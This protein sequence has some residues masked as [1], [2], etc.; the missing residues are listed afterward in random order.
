MRHMFSH[1]VL[2]PQR[3][4]IEA[5]PW[6]TPA[7]SGSFSTLFGSRILR[8]LDYKADPHDLVLDQQGL[9]RRRSGLSRPLAGD[10]LDDNEARIIDGSASISYGDSATLGLPD[11]SVDLVVTDPPFMDNVHYSELAD[12]FHAWLRQIRP[13]ASYPRAAT[14]R[15]PEEVQSTSPDEF[16]AGIGRV[17]R[18]ASRVMRHDGLLAF[19]FHQAQIHGWVVL[20]QALAD[21]ELVVTSIQPTKAEMSV[22]T[23]KAGARAPSNLDAIVVCRK[24]DHAHPVARNPRDAARLVT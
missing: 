8:A 10:I 1:H 19:T 13:F 20:V 17:W 16:G 7:S 6:G 23:P 3:T 5:H 18:E 15:S 21:A 12:F 14:T 4:P 2:R 22:A 9:P 24:P 11:G